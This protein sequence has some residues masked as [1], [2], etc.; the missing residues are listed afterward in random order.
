MIHL[1]ENPD[2]TISYFQINS[3][4]TQDENIA[5]LIGLDLAFSAFSNS[6]E[7]HN[8]LPEL[9]NFS[10]DQYFF[11]SYASVSKQFLIL[12]NIKKIL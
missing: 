9:Q 7:F 2:H 6:K 4:N 1:L 11:L 12:T 3:Q 10:E 5:D 8:K